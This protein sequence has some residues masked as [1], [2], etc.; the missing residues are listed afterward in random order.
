MNETTKRFFKELRFWGIHCAICAAP[1]FA[2]AGFFLSFFQSAQNTAAML[3]GVTLFV[4]AFSLL[5]TFWKALHDPQNLLSRA[6]RIALK[7]RFAISALTLF[8]L[9]LAVTVESAGPGE[10]LDVFVFIPDYWAGILAFTVLN[11][12]A[13][14]FGLEE[15]VPFSGSF[16]TTLIW[17]IIEGSILSF[18]LFLFSFFSLITINTRERRRHSTPETAIQTNS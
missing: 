14:F 2:I 5:S 3:F 16:H 10:I 11:H 17:T 9:L 6:L 13:T 12:S 1:S 15:I 4:F 7:I 18:F 8:V